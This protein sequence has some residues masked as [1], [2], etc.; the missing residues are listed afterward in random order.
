MIVASAC[1]TPVCHDGEV[2]CGGS[3]YDLSLDP[4]HCG[5]CDRAC[6]DGEVCSVGACAASCLNGL[7]ECDG[8]CVDFE[9]DPAHCGGCTTACGTGENCAGGSCSS[10]CDPQTQ[11][12]DRCVDLQSDEHHCGACDVACPRGQFCTSGACTQSNIAHVV[13]IVEENHTFD[14]HF[15]NYCRAP[16]GSNPTCTAGPDCC[17]AAPATDPS[18]ASPIVLDDAANE[19]K[20]R[21][22]ERVCEVAQ[23]DG[24]LMDHYVTGSGVTV[25]TLE[26]I[27]TYECSDPNTWALADATTMQPYWSLADANA[28]AD[29]Y[30]QPL[31][32][33]SSANDMYLA[34][35]R[36]QFDDNADFPAT[37][38]AGCQGPGGSAVQFA[39]VATV[40]DLIV[41]AGLTFKMYASGY[42]DAVAS[43]PLCASAAGKFPSDCE[44]GE[45]NPDFSPCNYDPSDLPFEYYPQFADNP[46]HLVDITQL[47]ADVASG[48]LPSFAYVKART[49]SDEHPKWSTLSRGVSFVTGIVQMIEQSAYAD[50]TLVLV[51]WDEGGGFF[52]HVPPPSPVPVGF[53]ADGAG[54]PVP[55]GTRVPMLA[56]GKFAR[57]GAISHVQLEHSSIVRFLEHN[58]LGPRYAGALRNRD[59]VV[60]N[61]GSLLDP[62][63]TGIV[64]P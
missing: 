29:R 27:Y 36:W 33:Q 45:M 57:T 20:D 30:F 9:S 53:D 5:A 21:D 8:R 22:H 62:T 38:G 3:C 31:A 63:T 7:G 43:A 40:A 64:I 35:A 14:N 50:S 59:Y 54:N 6:G 34:V 46:K 48:A 60:A 4:A 10:T 47:A 51:V 49:Y 41:G 61:L 26:L 1:G 2:A 18:G 52:D 17:E 15:G 13:L 28:L 25:G 12:G 23:I 56:I 58:F 39:H 11:C 44:A 16:A 19:T 42:A 55:Y 32:G 37:T 24:G